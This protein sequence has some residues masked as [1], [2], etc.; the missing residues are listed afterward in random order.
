MQSILRMK[1]ESLDPV[2]SICLPGFLYA[3]GL[4]LTSLTLARCKM[5]LGWWRH[6][7]FLWLTTACFRIIQECRSKLFEEVLVCDMEIPERT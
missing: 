4:Y 5:G 7:C 3:G 2:N 1:S 6:N